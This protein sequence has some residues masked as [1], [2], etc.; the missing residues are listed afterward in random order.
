MESGVIVMRKRIAMLVRVVTVI[1]VLCTGATESFGAEA[2]KKI[3]I[4]SK[5][6]GESLVPYLVSQ[7]LGFYREEGLDVDVIVTRGTVT[8]QV[9][10]SGAVDYG[11]GGSIPAMLG[12]ARLKILEVSTDKP[13]QYLVVSPKITNVKQLNGKSVAIS[14]ASGNSTLLLRELLAKNGVAVE[15]VQ[16]R[17]L[18][19][20]AVRLGALLAG[21]VDA[22]MITIG[23]AR[24]AQ[25]KGFR[26]LL[27]SGDYVSALSANLEASDDKIQSSPD[28]V[29]RV[30][31]ATLKGQIFYHRNANEGTKFVMEALRLNDFN[32]AK[33]I[34]QERDKQ[35]S[36]LAK[37]GRA[38]EEVMAVNIER[39]R[40]QMRAVGAASRVKG[41]VTLD[42]VYDFSFVKKAYDEIRASKWDPMRYEY[43]KK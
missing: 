19:E 13:S 33:E 24:L 26:I 30:V 6:A 43:S 3:R 20:P 2:L 7:R 4:A 17:A 29:Y 15:T 23:N 8:T 1:L 11:N 9:V 32:E 14:D 25:A 22:T 41:P 10:L 28:E 36:D 5:A 21:T 42:R 37:I 38:S 18:G 31:K 12:G 40:E 39:V 35:A 27:Y 34:W 16:L